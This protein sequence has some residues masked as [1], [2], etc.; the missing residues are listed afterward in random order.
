MDDKLWLGNCFNQ[1]RLNKKQPLVKR[2]EM[3]PVI[4]GIIFSILFGY[5]IGYAANPAAKF[6]YPRE[7]SQ[8]RY[9][10]VLKYEDQAPFFCLKLAKQRSK[11]ARQQPR[12]VKFHRCV[13]RYPAILKQKPQP[14]EG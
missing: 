8:S 5:Q 9:S 2:P 1:R 12:T 7:C 14:K 3:K 4:L 10:C 13:K 6:E 11:N